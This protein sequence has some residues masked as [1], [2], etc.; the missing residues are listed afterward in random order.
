MIAIAGERWSCLVQSISCL[1]G[2]VTTAALREE[3]SQSMNTP[4]A[5]RTSAR[6][7]GVTRDDLAMAEIRQRIVGL[8][9]KVPLLDGSK[10]P[11]VNFD[12][13]AT[14]PAL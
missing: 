11:Y 5:Y 1:S 2:S 3:G 8:D 14:T 9:V 12:N 13:A 7:G 6:P 4:S 10:R